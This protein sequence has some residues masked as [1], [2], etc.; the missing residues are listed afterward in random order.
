MKVRPILEQGDA[1]STKYNQAKVLI[2]QVNDPTARQLFSKDL[3]DIARIKRREL[4]QDSPYEPEAD[5]YDDL[6]YLLAMI[7]RHLEKQR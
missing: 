6:R 2:K 4:K 5:V 7:Q 1:F 3:G